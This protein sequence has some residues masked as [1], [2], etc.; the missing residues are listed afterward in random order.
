MAR[1]ALIRVLPPCST[2]LAFRPKKTIALEAC[3]F[4]QRVQLFAPAVVSGILY[5]V[6]NGAS[7]INLSSGGGD[8]AD[9]P[10][11]LRLDEDDANC[12]HTPLDIL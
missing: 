10:V 5:A 1:C 8:C 3:G 9:V 6:D 2:A 11:V 4:A 7:V 12:R